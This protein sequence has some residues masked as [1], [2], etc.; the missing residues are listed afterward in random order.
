MWF[1]IT[2]KSLHVANGL[3][4]EELLEEIEEIDKL[5]KNF[6]GF[7]LL[8]ATEVDIKADGLLDFPDTLLEKLDIVVASIHSGFKQGKEKLPNE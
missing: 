7:T 5:N 6:K 8:K 2:P 4:D 1:Q 3:K